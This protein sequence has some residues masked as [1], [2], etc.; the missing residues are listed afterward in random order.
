LK[1]LFIAINRIYHH[2]GLQFNS[3][4]CNLSLVLIR[5]FSR[6]VVCSKGLLAAALA[7]A[8][9]VD[10]LS[11]VSRAHSFRCGWRKMEWL[12]ID[13]INPPETFQECP[14]REAVNKS[15][16]THSFCVHSAPNHASPL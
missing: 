13:F 3:V 14:L 11:S 16:E 8:I 9:T 10:Q 12:L 4:F 5:L 15:R 7:F 2:G 1:R 6:S